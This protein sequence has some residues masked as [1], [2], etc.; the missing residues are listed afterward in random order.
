MC[1]SL[2]YALAIQTGRERQFLVSIHGLS[3]P[4]PLL[5]STSFG[6]ACIRSIG[7]A[8][9]SRCCMRY[10][11][12]SLLL[13]LHDQHRDRIVPSSQSRCADCQ[14]ASLPVPASL[15]PF[16]KSTVSRWPETLVRS[17]AWVFLRI[18]GNPCYCKRSRTYRISSDAI[19]D[20]G[21]L[22]FHH[23]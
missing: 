17:P 7:I 22:Y 15:V 18:P 23:G 12:A 1:A 2:M 8:R 3:L 21:W 20:T 10:M 19:S 13:P 9:P 4:I 16:L 11:T 5:L 14:K 6:L